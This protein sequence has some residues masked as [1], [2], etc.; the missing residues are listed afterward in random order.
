MAGGFSKTRILR[1]NRRS[2]TPL[3]SRSRRERWHRRRETPPTLEKQGWSMDRQS[4][5]VLMFRRI[6][7]VTCALLLAACCAVLAQSE[8]TPHAKAVIQIWMWGGPSQLDTFDPKPDAGYDYCGPLEQADPDQRAGHHDRPVA[9]AAG[10]AGR[11]VLH[12]PQHDPRHQRARD[13]RVHDADRPRAA[14]G[15]VYPS[16]RRGRVA[17][18]GLRSRLQGP[19]SAVRRAYGAAGA[20]FGG[21]LPGAALQAVRD[22]RRPEPEAVRRGRH[23]G[24]GHNRPAAARPPR[25]AAR[26]GHAGQGHAGHAAFCRRWTSART[27]PTI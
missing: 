27:R 15:L 2:E 3:H 20:V 4:G 23:R 6:G 22:R 11:Q 19:D 12:H 16:R 7:L 9:A 10:T 13:R 24:G 14:V 8:A 18:Q 5:T 1:R 21:R 17:V 26:A 25:A